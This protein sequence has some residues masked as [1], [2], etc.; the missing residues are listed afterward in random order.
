L[1]R[2]YQAAAADLPF[3]RRRLK[4]LAGH[5]G[6]RRAPWHDVA[7]L[8]AERAKYIWLELDKRRLGVSQVTSPLVVFVGLALPRVGQGEQS[9]YAISKALTRLK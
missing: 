8:I 2:L 6:A 3:V 7:A 5:T 9:D 4:D 1:I